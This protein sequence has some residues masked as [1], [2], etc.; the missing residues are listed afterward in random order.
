MAVGHDLATAGTQQPGDQPKQR[1]FATTRRANDGNELT[2]RNTEV[3]RLESKRG[4]RAP[5]KGF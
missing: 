4:N 5:L 2:L 3:D 1:A